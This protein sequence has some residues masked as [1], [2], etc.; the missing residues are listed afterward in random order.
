MPVNDGPTLDFWYEFASNYSYLSAMRIGDLAEKAGVG[1]RWRPF[2]L[3]PVFAAQGM[4]DSPFN[5]YPIKGRHMIRDME[6]Q[7]AAVGRS[8]KLPDPFPQHSLM[9][10]R[11]AL[12]AIDQGWGP[13]Y[14]RAVYTAEFVDG[15]AISDKAVLAEI[16]TDLG[17]DP[18][19]VFAAAEDPDNKARLK[20]QTGEALEIGLFGAPSFV[21]RDGELFWG[22]DRL[23]QA[24]H[25]A[26]HGTLSGL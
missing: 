11:V 14:T 10:A 18:E 13:D 8:F 4:N 22:D 12:V 21:T 2:L 19:T 6:R 3:G 25:W 17:H 16:V 23:E 20:T 7:S 5:I 1:V 24:L 26:R 9:A 15:R